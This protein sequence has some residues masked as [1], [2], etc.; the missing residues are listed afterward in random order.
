M[1]SNLIV[2][3]GAAEGYE[4][5][6]GVT[7]DH[8]ACKHVAAEPD[9]LAQS[10]TEANA[11]LDASM[12]IRITDEI[13]RNASRLQVISCATTGSDH[14]DH[15]ELNRRGIPVH[16]LREDAELLQSITPAAELSWALV[17]AAARRL[18]PALRHTA[19]GQWAREEFPGLMLNG[20]QLGL[21]GCGR[22]GRWMARYGNAFGMHVVGHDPYADPWPDNIER[23]TIERVFETSD[24]ISV[25]V[26]LSDETRGLVSADLFGRVKSG[27]IFINTS[28]GAIADETALLN[29]L[30]SG[31]LGAAGLDVLDGEP[32]TADHPLVAYARQH[33]NL[34]ITPH[35][36]GFS[37]DAVR[38][39]CR[40]AAEK[41]LPYLDP[42]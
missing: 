25:H 7:P 18:A 9:L 15:T 27:A 29:A 31:R 23:Q 19:E 10:L 36:G 42:D 41:I 28:R 6:R 39:V 30:Q 13:V 11:I 12:K 20:R 8:V 4:A 40:R 1:N 21:I 26:H 2:Y 17:L 32:N 35:C 33:D 37:P 22:I 5:L 14:I 3:V 24:V 34:L 16:T 38:R